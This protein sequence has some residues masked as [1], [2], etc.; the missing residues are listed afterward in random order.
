MPT[1]GPTDNGKTP[2][3]IDLFI[4]RKVSAQYLR[5]EEAFE[6][7]SNHSPTYL[8]TSMSNNVIEKEHAPFLTNKNTVWNCFKNLLNVDYEITEINN[9]ELL[10][11]EVIKLT[12]DIQNASWQSTPASKKRLPGKNYPSEIRNLIK[13]KRRIRK[14]WQQTRNPTT[15]TN[16]NRLGK[17][18]NNPIKELDDA[19]LN[20]YLSE[21]TNN[22]NTDYSL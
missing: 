6:L 20:K 12:N 10:E 16:L 22:K 18:I 9:T 19:S 5:V 11:N 17:F 8:T 13:E 3:L 2:D 15:K 21:L 1:Y 14:D 7:N 4:T